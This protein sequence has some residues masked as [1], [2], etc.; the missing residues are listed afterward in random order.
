M[1]HIRPLAS[2]SNSKGM[3]TLTPWMLPLRYSGTVV[4]P[5]PRRALS[6]SDGSTAAEPEYQA[7]SHAM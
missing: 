7:L 1:S 6:A 2:M 3:S 4:D 5:T